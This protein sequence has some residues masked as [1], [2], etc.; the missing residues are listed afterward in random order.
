MQSIV[1]GHDWSHYWMRQVE[2]ACAISRP[3]L[4]YIFVADNMGPAATSL[5]HFSNSFQMWL[6]QCNNAN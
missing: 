2:A 5:T 3:S 4:D 6:I 1:A